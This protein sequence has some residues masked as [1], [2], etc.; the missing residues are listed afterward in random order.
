MTRADGRHGLRPGSLDGWRG[1]WDYAPK[2][3][4][5]PIG[6]TERGRS[7]MSG[8]GDFER[9]ERDFGRDPRLGSRA[10]EIA[11]RLVEAG[12]AAGEVE[13]MALAARELGYDVTAAEVE[14]LV[15]EREEAA[16]GELSLDELGGV[17]GGGCICG[18][19]G[20][21]FCGSDY[22][23]IYAPQDAS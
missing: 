16:D 21:Q 18:S 19:G 4:A 14:R 10:R 17:A 2:L 22:N 7:S 20:W 12:E 15:A 3:Y 9:M 13:A 1:M 11:R 23:C 6:A 8:R 5:W